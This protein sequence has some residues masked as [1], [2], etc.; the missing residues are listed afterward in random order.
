MP[1]PALGPKYTWA[2]WA[3]QQSYVAGFFIL[4]GGII[5]VIF[6]P[7]LPGNFLALPVG[8]ATIVLGALIMAIE[9]P[10]PYIHNLGIA[11]TNYYPRIALYAL[12]L[13]VSM[14][15][16]PSQTGGLCLLCAI[17]TYLRAA[18]CGETCA[19]PKAKKSGK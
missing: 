3:N 18:L 15:Q 13:V 17:I 4:C 11:Y 10:I 7:K 1:L 6:Y 9:H 16:C 14:L 8:I 12:V 2:G 19:F 5:T